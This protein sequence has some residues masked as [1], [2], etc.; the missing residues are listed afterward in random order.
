MTK[1]ALKIHEYKKFQDLSENENFQIP[2]DQTLIEHQPEEVLVKSEYFVE[3]SDALK[4]V[5]GPANIKIIE[6]RST[7]KKLLK[8]NKNYGKSYDCQI[9]GRKFKENRRLT[10]H[11]IVHSE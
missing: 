7:K 1:K 2:R 9:C 5:E 3:A 8:L 6:V 4:A 10:L 11:K